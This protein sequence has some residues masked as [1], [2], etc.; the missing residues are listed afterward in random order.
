VD[1]SETLEA[2]AQSTEVVKPG[3]GSLYDPVCFSQSATMR[4]A[5]PGDFGCNASC[6]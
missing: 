6:M 2:D 3:D 5:S 1:E 4:L